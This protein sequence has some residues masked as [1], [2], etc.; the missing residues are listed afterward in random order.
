MPF[1][2]KV[3][4]WEMGEVPCGPCIE[5][6]FDRIGD[7]DARAMVNMDVP[8]VLEIW[9]LV[10]TQFNRESDGTL[11]VLPKKCVDTGMGL[12]RIA[13][14]I[15]GR[16]SNYDTDLFMPIFD[17]IHKVSAAVLPA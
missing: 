12:E 4:F 6:H 17:A 10:F 13:S 11:N 14:V 1:G 7:R 3:N 9:N 2:M 15:Q 16:S 8:D 5:I